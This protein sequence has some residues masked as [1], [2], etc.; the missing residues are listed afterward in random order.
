MCVLCS[1]VLL[2]LLS[3][4]GLCNFASEVAVDVHEKISRAF[5]ESQLKCNLL[6]ITRARTVDVFARLSRPSAAP[7]SLGHIQ[8]R[9]LITRSSGARRM[10]RVLACQWS[11][12][13]QTQVFNVAT[14]LCNSS[15]EEQ[16]IVKSYFMLVWL[17]RP[18]LSS[19]SC[20]F[21]VAYFPDK[22]EL[23]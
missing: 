9:R 3:C 15:G 18:H 13:V 17:Y 1:F 12:G 21:A 23:V 22:H 16:F 11:V 4:V 19:H 20:T 2:C 5:R 14:S 8:W 10:G 7:T 6:L